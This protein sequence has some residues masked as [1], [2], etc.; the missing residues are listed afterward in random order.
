[1]RCHVRDGAVHQHVRPLNGFVGSSHCSRVDPLGC[2]LGHFM[3]I[4]D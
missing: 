4:F 2:V 3:H 1:M